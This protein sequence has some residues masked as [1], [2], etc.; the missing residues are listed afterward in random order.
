LRRLLAELTSLLPRP[1]TREE[2]RMQ[3]FEKM[4]RDI[5]A[6]GFTVMAVFPSSKSHGFAYTIG[7]SESTGH[8]ELV[9]FGLPLP[10]AHL[11]L[12]DIARLIKAGARYNDGDVIPEIVN[13]PLAIRS[14]EHE[15]ASKY[16]VQLFN[17]YP[18]AEAPPPVMQ[19][20]LPDTQGRFPWAEDF[21]EKFRTMQPPLW[22][23]IH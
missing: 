8:P 9:L 15:M 14:V 1:L 2:K 11:V 23:V 5:A 12:S 22:K 17:M 10:V 3:I 6:L 13:M 18:S 21:D 16:T 7:L 4:E 19:L 20:V